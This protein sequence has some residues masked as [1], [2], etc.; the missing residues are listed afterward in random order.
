L[1]DDPMGAAAALWGAAAAWPGSA[2]AQAAYGTAAHEEGS[3]T[4]AA[5]AL[6]RAV[7]LEPGNLDY[8]SRQARYLADDGRLE[9]AAA[10]LVALGGEAEG[11]KPPL[12]LQ[13]GDAYRAFRPPR[14]K[15][16]VAAYEQALALD[17]KNGEAA[18]GIARA[19]RAGKQWQ[20]AADAYERVPAVNKRLEGEAMS[21]VAWS[22]LRAGDDYKAR[23]YTGLAVKAG[24]DVT[25]L[26]AALTSGAGGPDELGELAEDLASRSAAEQVK[27]VRALL[28]LGRPAVP[29]LARALG[30]DG[31]R[32]AAREAIVAGLAKLGPAARE[33]LPQLER[34]VK[35]GPRAAPASSAAAAEIREREEKLVAAAEAAA[36]AIRAKAPASP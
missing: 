6:T 25:A 12:L 29:A 33:A 36:A 22:Y 24:A 18:L 30:R 32:L 16:A 11:K 20:R 5:D 27:A 17:P 23:F 2:E 8:R 35:A 3:L 34:Q 13:L 19:Y 7:A 31:T 1:A 4:A 26:R 10:A 21:G 28:G 14:V 15:E 9:E